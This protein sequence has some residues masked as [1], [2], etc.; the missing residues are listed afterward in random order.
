MV[1]IT[2]WHPKG[3]V[4][5]RT[6]L[7]FVIT[8]S[9]LAISWSGSSFTAGVVAITWMVSSGLSGSNST[10]IDGSLF[11]QG[12]TST[13][14]ICRFLGH[15][16]GW[17][18]P[19]LRLPGDCRS[20]SAMITSSSSSCTEIG[21]GFRCGCTADSPFVGTSGVASWISSCRSQS[22]ISPLVDWEWNRYV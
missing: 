16:L 4:K 14:N 17:S 3:K 1:S 9:A 13:Q 7:T 15:E 11:E 2:L 18:L 20:G 8:A 5:N 12:G 21:L 10:E 22:A 6:Q 19:P